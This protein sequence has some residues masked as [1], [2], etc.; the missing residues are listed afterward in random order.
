MPSF[1]VIIATHNRATLLARALASLH[2]Q[3][4]PCQQI[5]V[6]S[7]APDPASYQ[8]VAQSMRA[9][10]LFVQRQGE[11]G[12]A[13]SRNIALSLVTGD[14]VLFLDDDDTFRP[15]FLANLA[16]G[17]RDAAAPQI[18]YTNCEVLNEGGA[19]GGVAAEAPQFIDLSGF[20]PAWAYVKNFIP[21][22]CQIFPRAIAEKIRF[23]PT[24]A[25]ED[26]DFLL[27]ACAHGALQH[28]PIAGPVIHKNVSEGGEHRGEKNQA[29]LLEC[30]IKVYARHPPP[31]LQV[32]EQRRLLFSSVGVDIEAFVSNKAVGD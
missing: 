18:F 30:Y 14:F 2:A 31:S 5:I 24:I 8:A 6:V 27:S 22:N 15:D 12:P 19:A 28:L 7:D 21:N 25:Y 11:P 20:P 1:S 13:H 26:W 29:G 16:A 9:G 23:E 32:A 3:T 10:D 17:L 4:W